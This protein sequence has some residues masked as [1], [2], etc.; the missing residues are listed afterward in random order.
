M[1]INL[2]RRKRKR[3]PRNESRIKTPAALKKNVHPR[4]IDWLCFIG[5]SSSVNLF[6]NF[7]V[8]VNLLS[9]LSD[10]KI[11]NKDAALSLRT[12]SKK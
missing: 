9:T 4:Q 11:Q 5:K 2:F 6:G 12:C 3:K 7:L 10:I 1:L 8:V